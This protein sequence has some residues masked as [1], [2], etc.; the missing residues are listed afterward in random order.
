[1]YSMGPP[2]VPKESTH[3]KDQKKK[4]WN[5]AKPFYFESYD[6]LLLTVKILVGAFGTVRHQQAIITSKKLLVGQALLLVLTT[7]H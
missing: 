4:R 1:M 2:K 6:S 3:H 5:L 7:A